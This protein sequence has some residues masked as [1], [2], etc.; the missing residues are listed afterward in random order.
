MGE[1]ELDFDF[2]VRPDQGAG[3][4]QH[5]GLDAPGKDLLAGEPAAVDPGLDEE[6]VLLVPQ[7]GPE[8]DLDGKIPGFR[9]HKEAEMCLFSHHPSAVGGG[10][11][12]GVGV[13][14]RAPGKVHGEIHR[15]VVQG[16]GVVPAVHQVLIEPGA[17]AAVVV[18][19]LVPLPAVLLGQAEAVCKVLLH[20]CHALIHSL[21]HPEDKILLA[22]VGGGKIGLVAV[23]EAVLGIRHVQEDDR[24]VLEPHFKAHGGVVRNQQGGILLG[25]GNF[26]ILENLYSLQYVIAADMEQGVMQS[27]LN[28]VA[29]FFDEP[30]EFLVAQK[31]DD[32]AHIDRILDVLHVLQIAPVGKVD[33]D[34]FLAGGMLRTE[35]I[36]AEQPVLHQVFLLVACPFHEDF[37]L[38]V[39]GDHELVE[40]EG[41]VGGLGD[42][43]VLEEGHPVLGEEGVYIGA[44]L[45]GVGDAQAKGMEHLEAAADVFGGLE[46]LLEVKGKGDNALRAVGDDVVPVL[47]L[48]LRVGG[49]V[50]V[51]D[52]I[53]DEVF[54][55]LFVDVLEQLKLV[56]GGGVSLQNKV[57]GDNLVALGVQL[58]GLD[59]IVGD[60][61]A[62]YH[63]PQAVDFIFDASEHSH[64]L[65]FQ[66]GAYPAV[67]AARQSW[68]SFC[69]F[70]SVH[71]V[72][73]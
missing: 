57:T 38:K 7:I 64:F 59:D 45:A 27:H 40:Q 42:E 37:F 41:A 3:H 15:Q 32:G 11:L 26:L 58:H 63:I 14:I 20:L 73:L 68:G 51:D 71:T 50:L 54:V 69:F 52:I 21:H 9:G 55:V 5:Q 60:I 44:A 24:L 61:P 25:V 19:E 53:G 33:K 36:P 30:V 13:D 31:A 46:Q 66:Y 29:V 70:A 62:E 49:A 17:E 22:A 10:Q 43:L 12:D 72:L 18:E 39:V 48:D 6:A 4:V 1:P 65:S 23:G 34:A 16:L 2:T 8:P 35:L 56:L 28:G 67:P 47:C